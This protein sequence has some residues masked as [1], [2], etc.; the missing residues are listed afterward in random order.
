[1]EQ[2]I[3]FN[4]NDDVIS[5]ITQELSEIMKES[6]NETI[7]ISWNDL[8]AAARFFIMRFEQLENMTL[9][10][11]HVDVFKNAMGLLK[12]TNEKQILKQAAYAYAFQFD[13][14]LKLFRG[15]A[16]SKGLYVIR[17]DIKK[18][19]STAPESY[20]IPLTSLIRFMDANNGGRLS[21]SRKALE[22]EGNKKEDSIDKGHVAHAQAAY[23]GTLN[24]LARF[25]ERKKE[26]KIAAGVAPSKIQNQS[27]LLMWK[28]E[29]D[30]IVAR[31]L[32]TGDL[33]EAYASFLLM[34]HNA[35]N[36][37]LCGIDMGSPQYYNDELIKTFFMN[38][39]SFVD[40]AKA[41]QHE[42][43]ISSDGKL[44][45]GVK[46]FKASMPQI[47]QYYNIAQWIVAN[48]SATKKQLEEEIMKDKPALRN[49]VVGKLNEI[50]DENE[51]ILL[52]ILKK[53]EE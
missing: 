7:S 41:L 11:A 17:G 5:E 21:A 12:A 26:K 51:E 49:I 31:V 53:I 38:H 47:S 15:Q 46:S 10:S 24:R 8:I 45:W 25:W 4:S 44:Q 48:S 27:G 43:I 13:D 19:G 9:S 29:H 2:N 18:R 39:V 37:K 35:V 36:D 22:K 23:L 32:N 50:T 40:N 14:K 33:K 30:W 28:E 42:D 20:E 16:P 34:A 1:M 3:N 52:D 6:V